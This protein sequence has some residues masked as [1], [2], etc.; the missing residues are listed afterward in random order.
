MGCRNGT[1]VFTPVRLLRASAEVFIK[2][3]FVEGQLPPTFQP[4]RLV[5]DRLETGHS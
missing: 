1:E 4:N 2:T 5:V 3:P